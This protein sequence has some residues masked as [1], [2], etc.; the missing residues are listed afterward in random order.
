MQ[1]Q[2]RHRRLARLYQ[3]GQLQFDEMITRRYRFE[4]INNA[5]DDLLNGNIIRGIIDFG[6]EPLS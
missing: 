6:G 4:D 5:Y 3:T 2:G 1:P